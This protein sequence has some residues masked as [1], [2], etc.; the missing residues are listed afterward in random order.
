MRRTGARLRL[1]GTRSVLHA[2]AATRGYHSRSSQP[3]WTSLESHCLSAAAPRSRSSRHVKSG[4]GG[5]AAQTEA[6][7]P[8]LPTGLR[9]TTLSLSSNGRT[10][11]IPCSARRRSSP[12]STTIATASS[13]RRPP[14]TAASACSAAS[15]AGSAP[16]RR[17][18][19][20]PRPRPAAKPQREA[21]WL[22]VEE[23]ARL[24]EAAGSPHRRR[25]GLAER[26]RL[27]LL[28][29]VRPGFA[30][31]SCSHS[32]G[33]TSRSTAHVRRCLSAAARAARPAASRSRPRS[34]ASSP[35]P[36]PRFAA[37][38]GAGLLRARRR[39][40]ATYDPRPDHPPRRRARRAR[41]ARHRA[42]SATPPRPGF[43]RRPA[44]RA[45]SPPTSATRTSRPSAATRTSPPTSSTRRP[46]RSPEAAGSRV[47]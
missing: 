40:A 39:P 41:Q 30:A 18:R 36:R 12:T 8:S 34:R 10:G 15:S 29:L 45:W 27:V 33:E 9:S 20:V 31:R 11:R 32:T 21:D 6:V 7:V 17:S 28:T 13:L 42:R 35:P 14:T 46:R 5:F 19:S 24:L 25:P 38:G 2:S 23:F 26:D 4:C 43:A 16:A 1:F 47:P 22:T 3:A 44:T 37:L